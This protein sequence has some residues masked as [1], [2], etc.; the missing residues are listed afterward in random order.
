MWMK[1]KMND[2]TTV[3]NR[4]APE[5]ATAAAIR[6][7][8][9]EY[10]NAPLRYLREINLQVRLGNLM[11]EKLRERGDAVDTQVTVSKC[12]RG[13]KS[14]VLS[15][16]PTLRVQHEMKVRPST[17][18]AK[19]R[20][21]IVLIKPEPAEVHL[22]RARNGALDVIAPI[23][24]ECIDAIVEIKAACS[25]DPEQR[26]LFRSDVAKLRKL[27]AAAL[28]EQKLEAHFVLI[29]KSLPVGPHTQYFGPAPVTV[30]ERGAPGG[31]QVRRTVNRQ[32]VVGLEPSPQLT[33]ETLRQGHQRG[34]HVWDIGLD[35]TVR[36]RL[37]TDCEWP[38]E[39]RARELGII[40]KAKLPPDRSVDSESV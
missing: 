2:E 4:P 37:C 24:L 27:L 28:P 15:D 6:D 32:K 31:L 10:M 1:L 9:T 30:W 22:K 23:A 34:V 39:E 26:H 12:G 38:K 7:L 36:H 14:A 33:L 3:E 16:T 11:L 5:S 20:S 25:F 40:R 29:D 21:D 18:L 19:D 17:G 13:A 35:L 8:L